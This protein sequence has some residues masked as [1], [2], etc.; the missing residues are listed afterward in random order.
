MAEDRGVGDVRRP[1]Q[2]KIP[3]PA[4]PRYADPGIGFGGF[5]GFPRVQLQQEGPICF[6]AL[7]K[8]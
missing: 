2:L 3:H 6:F 5:G 1:A 4:A 8:K 7:G